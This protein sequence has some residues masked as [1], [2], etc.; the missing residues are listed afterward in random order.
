[1]PPVPPRTPYTPPMYRQ[2]IH[3]P[4]NDR[5]GDGWHWYAKGTFYFF[6]N[7]ECPPFAFQCH[8]SPTRLLPG[9]W[10][11]CRYIGGLYGMW[12]GTGDNQVAPGLRREGGGRID[13]RCHSTAGRAGG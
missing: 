3:S 10:I 5:V 9:L 13:R 12:G 8:S 2:D 7:V 1:M 6:R 4:G 11:S